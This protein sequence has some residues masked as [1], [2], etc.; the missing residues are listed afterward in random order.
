MVLEKEGIEMAMYA[1]DCEIKS[2]ELRL[3]KRVAVFFVLM[4][5]EGGVSIIGV[6]SVIDLIPKISIK[7]Y[8]LL[9]ILIFCCILFIFILNLCSEM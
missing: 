3:P 5:I 4:G 1:D 8:I 7:Y 2:K 9:I 6:I